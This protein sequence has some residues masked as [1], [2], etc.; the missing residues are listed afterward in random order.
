NDRRAVDGEGLGN[1]CLQ[2]TRLTGCKT[3]TAAGTRQSCKVGIWKFDTFP[4]RRQAHALCL[5]CDQPEGGIVVDYHLDWQLM[6]HRGQKFAHQH[7]E[8]A[9]AAERNHLAR[10]IQRLY[11]VGLSKRCPHGPVVEGTNN[12]LR[13]TLPDPVPDQSVL[14]PVSKTNIASGLAR[15]LTARATACG[16]MRSLLRARSACSSSISS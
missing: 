10:A 7:I 9:I 5:Q 16:W 2:L 12:P 3:V 14:R 13:S 4:E 11:P 1:R 8:S 15:S 6:M